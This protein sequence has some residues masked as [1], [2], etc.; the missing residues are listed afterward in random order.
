MNSSPQSAPN[1][2]G[3]NGQLI[4]LNP[5]QDEEVIWDVQ[6]RSASRATS[7]TG[8]HAGSRRQSMDAASSRIQSNKDGSNE[9]F[10]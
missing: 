1:I 4:E 8:S 7:A 5:L 10:V 9:V 3:G 6:F 2:H